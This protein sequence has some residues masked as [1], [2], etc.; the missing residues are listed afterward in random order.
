[1]IFWLEYKSQIQYENKSLSILRFKLRARKLSTSRS[2]SEAVIGW[3][4]LIC[5]L[6]DTRRGVQ[7]GKEWG[8]SETFSNQFYAARYVSV[9]SVFVSFEC[10]KGKVFAKMSQEN[11]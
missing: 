9:R 2:C 5:C 11:Q 1:M 6:V 10:T 8:A 3:I 7:R 4:H